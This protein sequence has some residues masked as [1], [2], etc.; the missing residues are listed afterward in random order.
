MAETAL[1]LSFSQMPNLGIRIHPI[2][3]GPFAFLHRF[4]FNLR[5]ETGIG[6]T[7]NGE[8]KVRAHSGFTSFRPA[9]TLQGERDV[10]VGA[11][12][13][14]VSNHKSRG[15]QWPSLPLH[16]ER[17]QRRGKGCPS[18]QVAIRRQQLAVAHQF[19]PRLL[20]F[21]SSSPFLM[22]FQHHEIMDCH[23]W[24]FRQSRS[25]AIRAPSAMAANLVQITRGSTSVR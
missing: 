11:S 7:A 21:S 25:L 20:P 17:R 19:D 3:F 23:P 5:S 15:W 10:W 24:D 13:N 14:K 9:A 6:L 22:G 16:R 8:Q 4:A 12:A 18:R 2:E 1:S